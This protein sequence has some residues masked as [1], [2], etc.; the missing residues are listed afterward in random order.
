MAAAWLLVGGKYV[1]MSK[2]VDNYWLLSSGGPFSFP[3]TIKLQSLLGDTVI[4]SIRSGPQGTLKG[5]LRGALLWAGAQ[6]AA[7]QQLCLQRRAVSPH[8]GL[9][10]AAGSS[11]AAPSGRRCPHRA[12]AASRAMGIPLR[13]VSTVR[14]GSAARITV[15][16]THRRCS[17]EQRPAADCGARVQAR[18][19]RLHRRAHAACVSAGLPAWQAACPACRMQPGT[20][21]VPL[22][23]A[24]AAS[25]A[26]RAQCC[27]AD[28][29]WVL[30]CAALELIE[31]CPGRRRRHLRRRRASGSLACPAAA[32]LRL[33]KAARMQ[34]APASPR[35][36]QQAAECL[37]W[38]GPLQPQAGLRQWCALPRQSQLADAL[39]LACPP[40]Q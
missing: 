33:L 18:L 24:A 32:A 17:V 12:A 39:S 19:R 1:A 3:A 27:A 31:R 35:T 29:P 5:A 36:S 34:A 23:A 4:D 7:R 25:A 21:S 30:A 26:V 6:V 9:V 2:T 28:W 38:G 37:S 15:H 8:N 11:R 14:P 10:Q 20:E 16:D 13:L 40:P 22:Q